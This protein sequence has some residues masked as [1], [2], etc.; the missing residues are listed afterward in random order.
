MASRNVSKLE[1]P[2]SR[3]PNTVRSEPEIGTQG[4]ESE[5]EEGLGPRQGPERVILVN[6]SH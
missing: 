3:A 1:A 2:L 6:L 5:D 4:R